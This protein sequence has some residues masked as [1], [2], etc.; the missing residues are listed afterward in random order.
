VR[1]GTKVFR[2][3]RLALLVAAADLLIPSCR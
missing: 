2:G 1:G 3:T